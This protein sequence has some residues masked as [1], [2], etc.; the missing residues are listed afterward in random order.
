MLT[1]LL[2]LLDVV[3]AVVVV[4]V[5]LI[6][7]VRDAECPADNVAVLKRKRVA[8]SAKGRRKRPPNPLSYYIETQA[9]P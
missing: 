3:A 8:V 5:A 9:S 6:A 1:G 4:V 7:L 2:L